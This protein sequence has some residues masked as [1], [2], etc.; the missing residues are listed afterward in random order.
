MTRPRRH[1]GASEESS[2]TAREQELGSMYDYLAKIILLGPSGTGKSCL[3]HRFVKNEWRVLSSQTIG[4]E[5]A[6]KIIKV[7]TGSR[8]K[9]I[10]LQLWDTAGTERFRSVSRSYYRGAAGAILVYDLT[11]HAS[12]RNLQPFL[13]DARALASPNLSLMLV[14]NKLDLTDTLID[15]SLP[16]P[17]P[18]SVTSNSTLT[19]GM[20]GAGGSSYTSTATTRDRGASISAGSQQRATVAP[21]GREVTRAE[22][23]RWA[24]T[25]GIS[26]VTEA[27]AFNGEG[28]D[29]IFERLARI[30]L[31]KI[32]LGEIDPDDPASGIQYGD[33]GGWNT[34]SDG[35]SIKSSMTGATVEDGHS[36][37][38]RRRKKNRT[39]NWGLRE[40][41]E[42]FTLS[43]QAISE[44]QQHLY[45]RLDLQ[46]DPFVMAPRTVTPVDKNWQFKQEKEDD[47]SYLPVAQFPTNVHLDLLRHK[48]IPDP[49]IGKNELKV[50]WIGETIW[51]Y[52]TTFSSPEI[53][54]GAKAVLAFDGLDTFATV[55]LNGEKILET[56]NMFVPERVD[57]TK[58]LKKDGENDLRITFDAAYLRGWK[59]VEEHPDH[60]YVV[61]NGDGSR[62]P[63][64]KAQY[65]W[66]WDWGPALLTCGPWRPINLEV[67]ESHIADLYT[68]SEVE[69]SLKKADVVVHAAVEGKASRVRFE[70]SLDGKKVASETANVKDKDATTTFH[71][72][73]PALWYPV[74]YGKQPLYTIKATLLKDDNEIDTISKKIG[75]RK[76]ELVE[77]ELDGQPGTSFF[78][79]VNNIPIFCGGSNWIPADNFIPR[80]TKERYRDWV[81]L[82]ADGNQFMLRV[83]GGGIYEEDVFYDACDEFGILVW[84]DFMFACGNYPAWPDLLKS[85]DRE[86]RANIKRLRHHPSIVLWAGNNE[87]Y[88][89]RE[90]ENLIY[91][92]D[93]H[94]PESWLKTD[95]PAR[96]IYE[97]LLPDACKDLHPN[98]VYHIASPWGGKVT[99]DPTI[100]D[101]HQWNV[102]HGSQQKYQ[103]YDKLVGRFV[104][105]FGMEGFPDIKTIDA[106]LPQG[107]DDPERFSTSSTID[108]H[109]KADGQLRRLG[110]YMAEN[111]RFT[112]EPL[113]DYV[114]YSQLLQAE[115]LASA[116]RLW[117]RQWQG[118]KKEYCSGV[119]VWQTNDCWP[120]TSWAICDYYLRP[121][122]SYFTIKREMA[123][124]TIG[125]TR[126][127]H[128][129]PKNKYTRVDIETKVKVEIWGSNLKLEDV[130]VDCVVKA[131]DVETGKE[132]YSQTVVSDLVLQSNRSTEI[133][134][135][136]VPVEKPNA[137][138]EAKTV[139]AAYFYQDGKQIA[140]YVN[141]PEPLKYLHFQKPQNL[142]TEISEGCKSVEISAEVPIKGLAVLSEDDGVKF[143][144]NLVDIVPG[145][146]VKIGVTGA[147]KDT[148]LT[149]Q[150]LG[151]QVHNL[152]TECV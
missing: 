55:E 111:F 23:S 139:V 97:K 140:R 121:K 3:L 40:W 17:T 62:L 150:Y 151:M 26:V 1:S 70:V 42:V 132:T 29:E 85:I 50:Q 2:G 59:L 79:Q 134:T 52:K 36:G 135:L 94:D 112:L 119:L 103:D 66:G 83:W 128:K 118:P 37:L 101:I 149:T 18:T 80:I 21:E 13:N 32:E 86:A 82:V 75:L 35:G 98:T 30:I 141:W 4:V 126:R 110:L 71:I 45:Q 20:L 107:K 68:E 113:E 122:H 27:S 131:W 5:F 43:N 61:W 39:Q 53:L 84:Q 56:E 96:Y 144:D 120:V 12:F 91:D 152:E 100:G 142:K 65:H 146:V 48:K 44:S 92:F 88:Q 76:L 74:R 133:K 58:N 49:Y 114:Y 60:K 25:A 47:S 145:E 89:L 87:D 106:F 9:R 33:S 99:T 57:V 67:Y 95:F 64:R 137:D 14:G 105:E 148:V 8:R 125:M 93:D 109:N 115:A 116:Y 108:F 19:S 63:V 130:T 138:L 22:S 143:E 127:E 136:D 24:S 34:A 78:F 72:Q 102:W 16:P 81:K 11:S 31:T 104:S 10:K 73:D 77:R 41:E 15:T 28:V 51:V 7:G 117:K 147:K 124:I 38:R 90:S 6:T 46:R 123:P 54:D 69:K 129:H